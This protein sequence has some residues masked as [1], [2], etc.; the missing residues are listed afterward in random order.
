MSRKLY[1]NEKAKIFSQASGEYLVACLPYDFGKMTNA[2][3]LD[4]I[5]DNVVAGFDGLSPEE[6]YKQI[7]NSAESWVEFIENQF[8]ADE[9]NEE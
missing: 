2:E 8:F 1:E 6:V 4:Y 5:E 9:D 7:E 3:L